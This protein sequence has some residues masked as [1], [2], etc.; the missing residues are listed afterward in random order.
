MPKAM[1]NTAPMSISN[2]VVE[3]KPTFDFAESAISERRA[4][5]VAI[6][7]NTHKIRNAAKIPAM[8]GKIASRVKFD[9]SGVKP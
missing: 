6:I 1:I 3:N 9:R 2:P 7:P 8:K 4:K 5:N